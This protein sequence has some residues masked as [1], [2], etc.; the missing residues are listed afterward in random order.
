MIISL[1]PYPAYKDS[2]VPWLG[3]VPEHWE[4]LP[5]RAVFREINDLRKEVRSVAHSFH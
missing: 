4:V 1:K 3:S 2:G 5:G